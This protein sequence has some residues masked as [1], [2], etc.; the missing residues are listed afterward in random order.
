VHASRRAGKGE[1]ADDFERFRPERQDA[2]SVDE[3]AMGG[4]VGPCLYLE[5]EVDGPAERKTG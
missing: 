5:V 3:L 4:H 2:W 1:F